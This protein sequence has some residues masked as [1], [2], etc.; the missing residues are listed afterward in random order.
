MAF[1]GVVFAGAVFDRQEP[2]AIAKWL[3][4]PALGF[5]FS[6]FGVF[7]VW[8]IGIR[9][10]G[11]IAAG[12]AVTWLAA[13]IARRYGA[14]ALRLP[15]F[16]RRD[17]TCVAVALLVVPLITWAPYAHVREPVVEGEAYRAYFTADFFWALTVTSELAKGDVPPMNPFLPGQALNYYWMAHFLSGAVYRNVQSLGVTGEQVVLVNG[18]AFGLA[19]VA[20]FYGLARIAGA[21]SVFAA[22]AVV[23]AF[24]ANSYEGIWRIWML[25]EAGRAFDSLKDTNIDAVTR[26][27]YQGMP[28]DGLQRLL[29]YQPHHLTGYVMGLAALWLVSFA[30]DVTELAVAI[31]SGVFLALT[32]LFSTFTALIAG[33]AVALVYAARLITRGAWLAIFQCAVIAG[34]LAAAGALITRILGY[35]DPNAGLMLAVGPNPVALRRWPLALFLSLGPLLFAGAWGTLRLRWI[36]RDGAAPAAL[37]LVALAFYFLV[38][39]PDMEGVWVGWRSGHQLQIAFAIS[40]GAALTAV[41]RRRALRVPLALLTLLA[42]VPAVPTI[43]IDVYNAQDIENRRQGPSFPWTLIIT[44][45]EREAFEW[46]KRA[47]PTYAL[48]Q[49]EPVARGSGWWTSIPA[50]AERRMAA[51]LPIA[52]IPFRKFR[53]ASEAVRMG[54]F[55]ASSADE[56]YAMADFL[57]IDYLYIGDVERRFYGDS[58]ARIATR[59]DLFPELFRN[60]KVTIYGVTHGSAR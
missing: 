22:L 17:L 37:A 23:V 1:P 20:F 25:H 41:W 55:R 31:W 27:F 40:G 44:R 19:F 33:A 52:M 57:G 10:W 59:P 12:P 42:I 15:V 4:G 34:G 50:L 14:P 24:L 54:I 13:V 51:G 7:L 48:V 36:R 8:A 5:A 6:V 49:P 16:D 18:L 35:T 56:A 11:A 45:D 9:N 47:T 58:I 2:S 46:I 21:S 39:V 26:W 53:E 30:E 60:D 28:V 32:F 3:I 29:L 38:D 43:A